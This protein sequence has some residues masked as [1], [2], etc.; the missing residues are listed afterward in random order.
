MELYIGHWVWQI[1]RT[2]SEKT[3]S[4]VSIQ[5]Y[6]NSGSS[7]SCCSI[8][9]LSIASP[10]FYALFY[11]ICACAVNGQMGAKMRPARCVDARRMIA[12]Y[13][14]SLKNMVY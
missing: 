6:W 11:T 8:R 10:P 13:C 9:A 12:C 2:R 5:S 1:Q 3:S 14:T 7:R 4:E